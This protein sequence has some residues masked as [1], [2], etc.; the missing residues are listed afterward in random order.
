M[1]N[2]KDNTCFITSCYTNLY[3]T[4]MGGRASR[5]HQYVYSLRSISKIN[6]NIYVYV[7]EANKNSLQNEFKH[8]FFSNLN[9]ISYDLKECKYHKRFQELLN[10][11]NKVWSDRCFEIM[12]SKV[13]WLNQIKET[14]NYENIFWIDC[15]LSYNGLFPQK[16]VGEQYDALA[17][18]YEFNLFNPDVFTKLLTFNEKQNSL[19]IVGDKPFLVDHFPPGKLMFGNPTRFQKYHVVGGLFGG[20]RDFIT[21]LY[22]TY[23]E[24]LEGYLNNNLMVSEEGLL[25][26]FISNTDPDTMK[27]ENFG[28][29]YHEDSGAPFMPIL[30]R[31]NNSFYKIFSKYV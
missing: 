1:I 9:V 15:G 14:T 12:H 17:R 27:L 21:H 3:N 30:E 31:N 16:F 13:A 25:S 11:F 28:C 26:E 22:N 2:L 7:D 19:F 24:Y 8:R 29:W 23:N 20:T 10:G 5:R 6:S 18:Y 4:P